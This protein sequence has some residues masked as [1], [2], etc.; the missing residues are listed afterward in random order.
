M[1]G[2]NINSSPQSE[3]EWLNCGDPQDWRT[4]IRHGSFSND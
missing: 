1:Q 4:T 2:I 3:Q